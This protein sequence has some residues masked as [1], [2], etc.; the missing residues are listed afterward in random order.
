MVQQQFNGGSMLST[1][2]RLVWSHGSAIMGR[3]L[4]ATGM[5]EGLYVSGMLG[6]TPLLQSYLIEEY[7]IHP[8]AAGLYA[9]IV[10]GLTSS[11]A[12]QP[13]DLIKVWLENEFEFTCF[14]SYFLV[15][16]ICKPI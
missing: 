1:T 10:G 12:S 14:S 8:Q 2:R 4:L 16:R 11:L 5:R 7:K 6:I 13:F 3:G 9:S 15:R